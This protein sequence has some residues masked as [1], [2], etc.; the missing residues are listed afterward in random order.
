MV[1][2]LGSGESA[3]EVAYVAFDDGI[4]ED[5]SMYDQSLQSLDIGVESL[6]LDD[7]LH[8]G[9]APQPIESSEANRTPERD[10]LWRSATIGG[11]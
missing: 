8:L 7:S 11:D 4:P 2:E 5:Q 9:P 6:S 10:V 1:P 3:G